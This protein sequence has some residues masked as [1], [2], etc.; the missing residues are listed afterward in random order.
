[1]TIEWVNRAIRDM[2]RMRARDRERIIQKIEQYAAEPSSLAP[3]V[4]RLTGGPHLRL[5]VGDHRVIFGVERDRRAGTE[6]MVVLRV[7]HRREAYD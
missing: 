3:Q 5:R 1:M 7:R 4:V 6:T 2:R